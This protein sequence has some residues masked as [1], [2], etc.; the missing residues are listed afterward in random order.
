MKIT[1]ITNKNDADD[2]FSR[3]LRIA[4]NDVKLQEPVLEQGTGTPRVP[5]SVGAQDVAA[6]P[7][8]TGVL[9]SD[10]TFQQIAEGSILKVRNFLVTSSNGL[11]SELSA[12][13]WNE[14]SRVISRDIEEALSEL[15]SLAGFLRRFNLFGDKK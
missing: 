11:M 8:S 5:A 13:P 12:D 2:I 6:Q 10:K 1:N 4:I 14:K 9:N 15:D 3:N 7:P